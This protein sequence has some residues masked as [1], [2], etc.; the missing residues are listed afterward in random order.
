MPKF[1]VSGSAALFNLELLC[2]S[3]IPPPTHSCNGDT[4]VYIMYMY[5]V[6]AHATGLPV[7]PL[8]SLDGCHVLM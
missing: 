4:L 7:I 2:V 3:A 8:L 5:T 6:H 1:H